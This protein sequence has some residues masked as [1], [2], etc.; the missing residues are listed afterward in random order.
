MAG[1]LR[2]TGDHARSRALLEALDGG[3]GR[4]VARARAEAHLVCGELDAAAGW[5]S[6]A[7]A[8]RDPGVWLSLSGALGRTIKASQYWPGLATRLKLP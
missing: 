5:L 6:Q 3:R 1:M 2:R 4:G 7:V 8:E